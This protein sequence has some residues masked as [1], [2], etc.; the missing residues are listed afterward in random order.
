MMIDTK[1]PREYDAA[2]QLLVDLRDLSEREGHVPRF[3]QHLRELRDRHAKKP[4]LL[5]R[6]DAA[7]FDY[8]LQSQS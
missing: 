5:E 3:S 7:G 4:S 8:Q 6:I 1:K 2:V